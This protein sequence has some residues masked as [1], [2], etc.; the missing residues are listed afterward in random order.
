VH[1]F[2]CIA[3]PKTEGDKASD[4]C[5][6]TVDMI[7]PPVE[8]AFQTAMK[9]GRK[10]TVVD[11]ANVLDTSRLWRKV[12]N[13]IK[14]KYPDVAVDFMYVDNAVMQMI[15]DP[16]QFDVVV[17]ENMFGDILRLV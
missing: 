8:F 2:S 10:L 12:V 15:A 4:V 1:A 14:P 16:A 5:E 13:D 11:K 9:R 3:K 6:Y 7:V 17:T